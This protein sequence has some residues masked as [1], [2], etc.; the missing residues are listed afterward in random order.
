MLQTESVFE[1]LT[2]Q[3]PELVYHYCDPNA[4]LGIIESGEIWASSAHHQN[5][6]SERSYAGELLR[7]VADNLVTQ[8]F[9]QS[10]ENSNSLTMLLIERAVDAIAYLT[11]FSEKSDLL[12][13][14]RAYTPRTGGFCVGFDTRKFTSGGDWLFGRCLYDP[15]KQ[16]VAVEMILQEHLQFLDPSLP[17]NAL[18]QGNN[19]ELASLIAALLTLVPLLKHPTFIEEAEWRLVRGPFEAEAHKVEFRVSRGQLIP[20]QRIPLIQ[21]GE[22]L[23]I[24]QV[25]IGPSADAE[26]RTFGATRMLLDRHGLQSCDLQ[27]SKIPYRGW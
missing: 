26:S 27:I 17:I 13:Q 16:R 2:K 19:P 11:C 18:L 10:E 23:P 3:V 20:F 15:G 4:F 12:S 22:L 21:K 6:T 9:H 24:A 25:I 5:D 1:T 7:S 14:W 8:Y